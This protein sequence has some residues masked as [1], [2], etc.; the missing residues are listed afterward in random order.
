M[1]PGGVGIKF[2]KA[3]AGPASEIDLAERL[4]QLHLAAGFA[5]E[6]LR[7]LLRPLDRAGVHGVKLAPR[8]PPGEPPGLIAA[9]A[10]K[11][12]PSDAAR[13]DGADLFVGRMADQQNGGRQ[14]GWSPC[15]S[16]AV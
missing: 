9:F 12:P 15:V 2:G 13:Q 11:R 5:G 1:A 3:A 16:L 4:D 8:K 7:R 6:R 10:R 14:D